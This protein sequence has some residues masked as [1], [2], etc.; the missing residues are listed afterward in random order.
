MSRQHFNESPENTMSELVELVKEKILEEK[1][2]FPM[3]LRTDIPFLSKFVRAKTYNVVKAVNAIHT[4]Y[5]H[6]HKN[7][8]FLEGIKSSGS[9]FVYEL[10]CMQVLKRRW[11]GTTLVYAKIENWD[12][13]VASLKDVA[14]ATSFVVEESLH[15][16]E[17]QING[18]CVIMDVSGFGLSHIREMTYHNLKL[19]IQMLVQ[20]FPARIGGIHFVNAPAIFWPIFKIVMT[21][22][23]TKLATRVHLHGSL[24]SL[25]NM[26]TPE[27]LPTCLGGFLDDSEAWDLE[28]IP[29]LLHKNISY[30]SYWKAVQ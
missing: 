14:I 3:S 18:F 17:F 20:T 7:R 10:N 9:E 22:L 12:T 2:K 24:E 29:K 21:L 30:D 27:L 5:G 13:A 6:I 28:L 16:Q 26:I 8:N 19:T 15:D 11:N 25:T 23:S 1:D 4:Y